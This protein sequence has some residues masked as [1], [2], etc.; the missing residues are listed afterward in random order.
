VNVHDPAVEEE[1]DERSERL[2]WRQAPIAVAIIGGFFVALFYYA[3]GG[4]SAVFP[5]FFLFAWV[6]GTVTL[7]ALAVWVRWLAWNAWTAGEPLFFWWRKQDTLH[8]L[9]ALLLAILGA[10]ASTVAYAEGLA[11]TQGAFTALVGILLSGTAL[12][13]L[14][15]LPSEGGYS[16]FR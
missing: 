6:A 5:G 10:A 8:L 4:W 9:A 3:G 13:I 2:F 11:D 14:G 16:G 12:W 15:N 1:L 7:W